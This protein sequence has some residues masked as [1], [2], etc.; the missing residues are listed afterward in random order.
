[1][2]FPMVFLWFSLSTDR[3]PSGWAASP[4]P[5][6]SWRN[7][8]GSKLAHS[9]PAGNWWNHVTSR[10][11]VRYYVCMI[12]FDLFWFIL[13][14]FDL[15]WFILI[16]FVSTSDRSLSRANWGAQM[17]NSLFVSVCTNIIHEYPL[18]SFKNSIDDIQHLLGYLGFALSTTWHGI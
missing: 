7:R 15:F 8:S 18:I 6:T 3:P 17:A 11:I 9:E 12:Y 4:V 2:V 16:D 5:R 1:M 14:Y 10:C 13:I